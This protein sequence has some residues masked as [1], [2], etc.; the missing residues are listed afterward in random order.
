MTDRTSLKLSFALFVL[1][2]LWGVSTLLIYVGMPI[3]QYVYWTT[4][5]VNQLSTSCGSGAT[6]S[7][8]ICRGTSSFMP[9]LMQTLRMMSPFSGYF[10][11]SLLVFAG[12]LGWQG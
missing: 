3:H 10:A 2:L 1:G 5:Q 6:F 7:E 8:L 9:F 11:V 12:L 4:Q